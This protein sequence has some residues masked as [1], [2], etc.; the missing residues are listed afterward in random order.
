MEFVGVEM[1]GAELS[2][3]FNC[4][5]VTSEILDC[6]LPEKRFR[7]FVLRRLEAVLV[8]MTKDEEAEECNRFVI[9]RQTR[10]AVGG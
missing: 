6:R 4:L 10:E 8:K 5:V 3:R 7:K 1:C 2:T 9:S